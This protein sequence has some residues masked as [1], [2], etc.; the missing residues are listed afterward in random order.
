MNVTLVELIIATLVILFITT[1]IL[2]PLERGAKLFPLFRRRKVYDR[3]RSLEE[4]LERGELE[5]IALQKEAQ[6]KAQKEEM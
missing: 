2:L 1:Q 6:L 3:I 4:A 5:R